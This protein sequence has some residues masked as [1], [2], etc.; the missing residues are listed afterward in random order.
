MNE[1]N[2]NNSIL[3]QKNSDKIQYIKLRP[4]VINK[5]K[6]KNR[7]NLSLKNETNIKSFLTQLR[8]RKNTINKENNPEEFDQYT[9]HLEHSMNGYQMSY[10]TDKKEDEEEDDKFDKFINKKD[11][12]I[13]KRIH[14]LNNSYDNRVMSPISKE[15]NIKIE[16]NEM[17]FPNPIKSLGV[18]RNNRHIYN[19][20]SKNVLS[21]QSE[22]FNKQIEEV[23]QYHMKYGKKMPKIHITDLLVKES[24]DIPLVN[25]SNKKKKEVHL[26][27]LKQKGKVELKLFCYYKYPIKNFPEGREQFSICRKNSEII[28]SGGICSNMKTLSIWSLNMQKLEWEKIAQNNPLE[29]RYGHTAL[30]INNK[31]YI[32]GGKTKYST[33]SVL[34]GLEIFSFNNNNYSNINP[35]GGSPQNRKNHISVLV[36]SQILIHGGINEL[37]KVLSDTYILNINPLK[38]FKCNIDKTCQC[39]KLFGHAC[40]LVI[41]LS[42][43]VNPKFNIYSFPDNE[44]AKRKTV[45][46]KGLYVFGGKTKEEGGLSNQ[47]WILVLGKKT[48]EWIKPETKGKPPAARYFHTMNYYERGNYLIIHGGRN[49]VMSDSSALNDTIL[50]NLENFEWMGVTLYS[51]VN[52]FNIVSRCGHQ[53]IVYID[54]LIIFGGMNNNNYL[55]SSLFIINLDFTYSNELKSNPEIELLE[56]EKKNTFEA[57]M[58]ISHIKESLKL[59]QLGVIN[60]INL[61][62][63]K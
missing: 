33:S 59:K 13:I 36:G 19:D 11:K 26:P 2:I 62:S 54:K 63:I 29:N 25:L 28:I 8:S 42:F 15:C 37:G 17:D 21:R 35:S 50:L 22:S 52:N 48:L 6:L 41:P 30:A 3:D 34:N 53:S 24:L 46:E 27:T 55:G 4:L 9:E 5:R 1:S 18:I 23:E 7:K 49:D 16:I 12:E 58:K 31:L 45:K 32:Y 60:N 38:W 39:P 44:N 47:L 40:S 51:N 61:P 14:D 57:R 10:S 56:L 20:I 43:L